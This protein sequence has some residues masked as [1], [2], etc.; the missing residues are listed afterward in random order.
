MLAAWVHSDFKELEN[1]KE[2]L[3]NKISSLEEYGIKNN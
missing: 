1:S 2:I 3:E